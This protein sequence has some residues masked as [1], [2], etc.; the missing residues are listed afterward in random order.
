MADYASTAMLSIP[1]F[2]RAIANSLA[3]TS[4]VYLI[5]LIGSSAGEIN[6]FDCIKILTI[7]MLYWVSNT[8][9]GQTTFW[10][11]GS[12]NYLW[13]NMFICA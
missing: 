7:F 9:L 8:N 6:K 12:A 1:E 13:T 2:Y 3:L 11:V 4:S 5:F 10:I